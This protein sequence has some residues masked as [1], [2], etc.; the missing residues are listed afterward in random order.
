MRKTGLI[1]S[2]TLFILIQNRTTNSDSEQSKPLI[3]SSWQKYH[4]LI[5]YHTFHFCEDKDCKKNYKY[6]QSSIQ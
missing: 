1:V 2:K 4:V 6:K 5:L 3:E